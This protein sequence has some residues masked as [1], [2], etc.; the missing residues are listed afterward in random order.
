M[1]S[2]A[3]TFSRYLPVDSL[4]KKWGWNLMDAGRQH[5]DA[6]ASYPGKGHPLGYLFD[7]DGRR[8]LDEYQVVFI[9]AGKGTFTSK[10]QP[11]RTIRAGDALILFPGEWHQY[12]PDPDTG[13]TEYWIGF[14]GSEAKRLMESFFS[15]KTPVQES[16]MGAE[17]IRQFDRLI[18]WLN[19]PVHERDLILASHIPTILSFLI[20]GRRQQ[21]SSGASGASLVRSAKAHMLENLSRRTDLEELANSLGTSYSRLRSVFKKETGFAPRQFEN[22]VKLNRSKD[23]LLSGEYNISRTAESLGYSSVFYFSRAF[24]KAFGRSPQEWVRVHTQ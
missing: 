24:R 19:Q 20:A 16:S 2:K 4:A 11:K 1:H 15:P 22:M 3:E 7:K 9:A 8:I 17:L 5:L 13:W 23:L 10:S 18:H 21:T 6:G 14:K 12:R